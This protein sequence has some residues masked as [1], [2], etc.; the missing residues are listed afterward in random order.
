[1][2][3][4]LG[5]GAAGEEIYILSTL[6]TLPPLGDNANRGQCS[7]KFTPQPNRS[8]SHRQCPW[9]S[10][11]CSDRRWQLRDRWWHTATYR[12]HFGDRLWHFVTFRDIPW[13][14]GDT[15]VTFGDSSETFCDTVTP[16]R[17][18]VILRDI[19]WHF[20]TPGDTWWHLVTSRDILVTFWWHLLTFW[21]HFGDTP[22]T[23][24]DPPVTCWH[25]P[26]RLGGYFCTT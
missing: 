17:H 13:H 10:V 20:V 22:V 24:S 2:T 18:F 1:M 11:I 16:L 9:C 23:P 8:M 26:V 5:L 12:W 3:R 19:P 6:S 15:L 7:V 21:W 14:F 4:W 25:G